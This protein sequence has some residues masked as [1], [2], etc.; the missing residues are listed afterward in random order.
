MLRLCYNLLICSCE[1]FGCSFRDFFIQQ[2]SQQAYYTT[3]FDCIQLTLSPN[4]LNTAGNHRRQPQPESVLQQL[5]WNGE[6]KLVQD[7]TV[8]VAATKNSMLG[9]FYILLCESR[10]Y[11][12][13]KKTEVI[14]KAQ[15]RRS[16]ISIDFDEVYFI[17]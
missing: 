2:L 17:S 1:I 12:K 9:Y 4:C 14:V 7:S 6:W 15:Y 3:S 5:G 16:L 8:P 10:V 11:F 13:K